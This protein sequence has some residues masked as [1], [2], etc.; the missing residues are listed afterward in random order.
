MLGSNGVEEWQAAVSKSELQAKS[1]GVTR[2]RAGTRR[3]VHHVGASVTE[4]EHG[5]SSW[6]RIRTH[7]MITVGTKISAAMRKGLMAIT[8]CS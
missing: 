6:N 4:Q 2:R 1:G 8:V 5:C 7:A 3:R